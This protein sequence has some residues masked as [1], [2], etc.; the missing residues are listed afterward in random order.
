MLNDCIY[1]VACR[2]T[3]WALAVFLYVES[4]LNKDENA[5]PA[6]VISNNDHKKGVSPGNKYTVV[7]KTQGILVYFHIHFQQL[8]Q[9]LYANKASIFI[10][11]F[12]FFS[13]H[14]L[15]G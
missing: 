5:A 8:L 11:A 15:Y 1:R 7:M 10:H 6:K 13:I 14:P 4:L 3:S 12:L 9:H 2:F